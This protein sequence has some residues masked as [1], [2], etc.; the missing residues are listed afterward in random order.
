MESIDARRPDPTEA[1]YEYCAIKELVT[2]LISGLQKTGASE[3]GDSVEK[4]LFNAAE[5]A[6]TA[7]GKEITY[8]TRD[9]RY[10]VDGAV[11]GRD[12]FSPAHSDIAVCCNP[13]AVQV[14]PLYVHGMWMRTSDDGL[15]TVLYGPSSVETTVRD[16]KVRLEEQTDYPFSPVVSI[17][18]SPERPVEF[19]LTLRNPGW[20]EATKLTCQGAVVNRK[21]DYFVV[22]KKWT[23]GDQVRAEFTESLVGIRASNREIY[24]KRGAL[25]YALRIPESAVEIKHY[26]LPGFADL[27]FFPARGVDWSYALDPTL[28]KTD[29]GFTFKRDKEANLLY[30]FDG[31]PVQLEGKMINLNTNKAE[32]LSLIPMGSS[33]ARLRRVTFPLARPQD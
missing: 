2:S 10:A 13:N 31:A 1:Y 30:P 33:L 15:A 26:K 11:L 28:G 23:M 22:H 24:L 25:V 4:M 29:Y 16:V 20:S 21:G 18:I 17:A 14:F 32:S 9:N 6:R 27:A 19:S 8:C 5:G 7:H 3:L 12:K